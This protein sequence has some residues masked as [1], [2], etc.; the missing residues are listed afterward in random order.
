MTLSGLIAKQYEIEGLLGSGAMGEVYRAVDRKMFDRPVAVKV[1]NEKLTADEQGR[2]RFRREIKT[3]ATLYHPNI[4]RLYDWGEHEGRDFFVMELVD[5]HDLRSLLRDGVDWDLEARLEIAYQI[6]DALDFAHREGVV[7][8]DI[9]PGNVM[10]SQSASGPRVMLVDFGIAHVEQSALTQAQGQPGTYSYMSPEQL[11]GDPLDSRSDLFSLGIVF[12]ELF[13]GRHPFA[14]QSEALVSSRMLTEAPEPPS[15]N[16]PDLPPELDTLVL[17]LLAKDAAD[18]PASARIVAEALREILRDT[19]AKLAG[20]EHRI[21]RLKEL[22]QTQVVDLVTWARQKESEGALDEALTAYGKALRLDPENE[23]VQREI[24]NLEPRLG[25]QRELETAI[26]EVERHLASGNPTGARAALGAVRLLG[27]NDSRLAAL[28]P[29]VAELGVLSPE[30]RERKEFVSSQLETVDTTLEQGDVDRARSLLTQI[31]RKYP[32]ESHAALLLGHL[33][34][35]AAGSVPYAEYRAELRTAR[36][37]LDRGDLETATTSCDRATALWKDGPELPAMKSG[38][39]RAKD[40]SRRVR[41]ERLAAEQEKEQGREREERALLDRYLDGVRDSLATARKLPSDSPEELRRA[42]EAFSRAVGALELV[43]GEWPDHPAAIELRQ[44]ALEKIAT[45]EDRLG[46]TEGPDPEPVPRQ[47]RRPWV[48]GAAAAGALAVV[49]VA[50]V[51]VLSTREP[52]PAPPNEDLTSVKLGQAALLLE[53]TTDEVEV[54]L[55]TMRAIGDLTPADHPRRDEVFREK[56]RLEDLREMY[57]NLDRLRQLR[58][59]VVANPDR[60]NDAT[61]TAELLI[62][63]IEE[64]RSKLPETDPSGERVVND[65]REIVDGLESESRPL[66][67]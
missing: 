43:L 63:M 57:T 16:A 51:M 15:L 8:R 1:L 2:A 30:D 6:A 50:V 48:V 34:D 66:S 20:G 21:A 28:E 9:K 31:L 41:A 14:A 32:D 24:E 47:G 44:Q 22:E 54:K 49:V 65:A 45:F 40:D 19:V 13:G 27:A 7:H 60:A 38:I 62:R 33:V 58:A 10:V 36:T 5:G 52:D 56:E 29:R 25:R 53:T 4:V 64:Y 18:R 46:H 37:A 17:R 61:K 59:D 42:A 11:R 39:K 23:P 26:V 3:C 35:I 67:R 12:G 55:R